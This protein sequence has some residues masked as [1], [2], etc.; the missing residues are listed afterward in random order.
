MIHIRCNNVLNFFGKKTN[1]FILSLNNKS[2]HIDFD[3][4]KNVKK[5]IS[6][7]ISHEQTIYLINFLNESLR[8]ENNETGLIS[9][10]K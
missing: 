1:R 2:L 6:G 5:Y 9:R 3:Q 4:D 7:S 8:E 10:K